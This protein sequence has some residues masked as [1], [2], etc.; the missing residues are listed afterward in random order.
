MIKTLYRLTTL[1]GEKIK[2][3]RSNWLCPYQTNTQS[4]VRQIFY[5]EQT[6]KIALWINFHFDNRNKWMVKKRILKIIWEKS[7]I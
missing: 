3:K 6:D 7:N 4:Y 5:D 2:E 1:V